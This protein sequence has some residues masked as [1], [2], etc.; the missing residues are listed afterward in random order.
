MCVYLSC[1]INP[2]FGERGQ[3]NVLKLSEHHISVAVYVYWYQV[4]NL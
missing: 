3:F 4:S 2:H 1:K